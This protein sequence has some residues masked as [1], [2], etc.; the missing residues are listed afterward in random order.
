MGFPH[1]TC[2]AC[3]ERTDYDEGDADGEAE[4]TEVNSPGTYQANRPSA[5]R[6]LKSK[7]ASKAEC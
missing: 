3:T 6:K 4:P 7:V 1:V 2:Q 5:I